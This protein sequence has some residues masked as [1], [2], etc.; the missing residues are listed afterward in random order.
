VERAERDRD[1][2]LELGAPPFPGVDAGGVFEEFWRQGLLVYDRL[3]GIDWDWLS[4]DGLLGKTPLGGEQ[5]G[6]T[7]LIE[8]KRGK[9]S[10]LC[11][12]RAAPLA[13]EIAGANVNDFKL[14]R[15]TFGAS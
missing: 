13:V 15:S 3:Q 11:D 14:L 9:R 8:R 4:C 1:L 6:R 12:G 2:L 5:T 7:P 10:L